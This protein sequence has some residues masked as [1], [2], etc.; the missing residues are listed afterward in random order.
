MQLLSRPW[1]DS[2][3]AP[4]WQNIPEAYY[5]ASIIAPRASAPSLAIT[6][7]WLAALNQATR[8]KHAR[9][10]HDN[11]YRIFLAYGKSPPTWNPTN[12]TNTNL[13]AAFG[14]RLLQPLDI[15]H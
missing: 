6:I 5:A 1:T 3:D 14:G 13:W 10:G 8:M 11:F 9:L 12:N 15:I 7:L 4:A 2:G